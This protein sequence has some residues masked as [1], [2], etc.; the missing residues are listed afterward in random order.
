MKVLVGVTKALVNSIKLGSDFTPNDVLM[1]SLDLE[2]LN[3]DVSKYNFVYD[4]S[5]GW[6]KDYS[7]LFKV[8]C[9]NMPKKLDNKQNS[10]TNVVPDILP[11]VVPNVVTNT[12]TEVELEIDSDNDSYL[13]ESPHEEWDVSVPTGNWI[14]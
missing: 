3:I 4:V 8:V 5:K 6:L 13:Y 7:K 10:D 1:C 9:H 14:V 2:E 11:N 12:T